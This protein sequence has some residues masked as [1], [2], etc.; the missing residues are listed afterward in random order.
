MT[1][2]VTSDIEAQP[3]PQQELKVPVKSFNPFKSLAILQYSFV[4][5][6]AIEIGVC[7]GTMF[8]LETLIPDLYY[9]HYSFSSWQTGKKKKKKIIH[10]FFLLGLTFIGAGIGNLLGSFLSG[11]LSDYFLAKSKERRGGI[12]KAEDRITLNAWYVF[13][14]LKKYFLLK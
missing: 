1:T 3:Q 6:A 12:S 9:E 13:F 5:F 2:L 10:F 7:F 8:T 11:R 14:F 4:L